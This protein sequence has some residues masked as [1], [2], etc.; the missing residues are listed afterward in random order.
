MTS[1]GQPLCLF[2][3]NLDLHGKHN[4]KRIWKVA[5][6]IVARSLLYSYLDFCSIVTKRKSIVYGPKYHNEI[7]N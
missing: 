2:G 1:L 7:H 3:I 5:S 4:V 6:Y